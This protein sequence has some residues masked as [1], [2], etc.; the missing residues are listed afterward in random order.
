MR[1]AH[2][3]AGNGGGE[4]DEPRS[5]AMS[6]LMRDL[7]AQPLLRLLAVNGL[8]G[9]LAGMC[10]IGS[11]VGLDVAGFRTLLRADPSA[12]FAFIALSIGLVGLFAGAAMASAV[13]LMPRQ[14]PTERPPTGPLVPVPIRVRGRGR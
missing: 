6:G 2:Q 7:L 13:M 8:I 14:E 12:W 11:M 3:C 9:A 10:L 1:R 5:R 4:V